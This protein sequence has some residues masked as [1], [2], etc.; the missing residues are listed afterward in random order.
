MWQSCKKASK[1]LK[2]QKDN[3]FSDE[4]INSYLPVELRKGK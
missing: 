2:I 4:E 3:T 1:A